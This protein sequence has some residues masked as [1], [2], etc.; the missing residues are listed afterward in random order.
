[1]AA[2]ALP[3][4]DP[5]R[6]S[7]RSSTRWAA[8]SAD[9]PAIARSSRR[10]RGA[11]T[12]ATTVPPPPAGAAVGARIA[13]GRR[14]GPGHRKRALRRRPG[15]DRR[16]APA[17]GPLAAC[18]RA[19]HASATSTAYAAHAGLVRVVVAADVP[20]QN[21]YG[22]YATGKDQ[23]VARRRVRP[24]SRRS[25]RGAGRRRRHDRG[26]P[27][28]RTADHLGTAAEPLLDPERRARRRRAAA[29]RRVTRQSS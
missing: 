4:R 12:A 9:A 18:A 15:A 6:P 10:S 17:G 24:I 2:D 14:H 8:S 13:P 21:R 20:G 25:G 11:S 3:R 19:L 26:D 1:M 27:G 5:I 7:P 29:P 28:R 23:P 16:A 22:I